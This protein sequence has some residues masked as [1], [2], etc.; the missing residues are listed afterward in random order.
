[1]NDIHQQFNWLNQRR[2]DEGLTPLPSTLNEL[3]IAQL[4]NNEQLLATSMQSLS[5]AMPSDMKQRLK[6]STVSQLPTNNKQ[7]VWSFISGFAACLVLVSITQLFPLQ[8]SDTDSIIELRSVNQVIG[9]DDEIFI[10][11]SLNS[12]E[13]IPMATINVSMNNNI[14][15]QEHVGLDTV[16]WNETLV[17]GNNILTLPLQLFNNNQL[18]KIDVLIESNDIEYNFN[19][20]TPSPTLLTTI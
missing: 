17:P 16:Q 11:V 14:Q 7:T 5:T 9:Y 8:N 4:Y 10:E 3:E 20:A 19:I 12:K 6:N 2:S 1:M 18:G 13:F 15:H